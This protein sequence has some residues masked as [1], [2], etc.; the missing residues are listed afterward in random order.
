MN[1]TSP[2]RRTSI[3]LT[4]GILLTAV[5]LPGC[6]PNADGRR[7]AQTPQ[8]LQS[9]NTASLAANKSSLP[10]TTNTNGSP[11][12]QAGSSSRS[13][14]T[15]LAVVKSV[16]ANLRE[17]PNVSS[18]VLEEVR[19]G[20]ALVL[21]SRSPVGPWYK[22]RHNETGTEGWIH[23][24]GIVITNAAHDV[25]AGAPRQEKREAVSRAAKGAPKANDG[26]TTADRYYRNVD[27]DLVRSPTF[28]STVP[29]G[30]T[31]RC[32]DGSYSFSRHRRGTCSHHG[33]V[34]KWLRSDIP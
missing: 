24:N 33:G 23:G 32:R 10:A 25:S 34:A 26:G 30:A 14:S 3:V 20:D 21:V 22:V 17:Q 11:E 12:V 6:G 2:L 13:G 5:L 28:S 16:R 8:S 7:A 1:G 29:E 9:A 19:Q 18:S 27:G 4:L 31:A 15:D